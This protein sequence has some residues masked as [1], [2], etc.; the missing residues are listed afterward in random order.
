MFDVSSFLDPQTRPFFLRFIAKLKESCDKAVPSSTH[1]F[2][3]SLSDKGLLLRGYTQNIDDLES[4]VGLTVLSQA[5]PGCTITDCVGT[6]RRESTESSSSKINIIP[7]HGTLKTVA[8]TVCRNKDDFD[9]A[10][11]AA[12]HNGHVVECKNCKQRSEDRVKQ[13][14][15][16]LQSG[17][18]RPDIVL[19]NEHHHLGD[20]ISEYV[21]LDIDS[22]PTTVIVMGTSLR[23]TG[24]KKLVKDMAKAVQR[25]R[26]IAPDRTGPVIYVNKTSASKS[27]WRNVFDAEFLGTCDEWVEM[28]T[29]E[30]VRLE[31][32]KPKFSITTPS[33]SQTKITNFFK[34]RPKNITGGS[35]KPQGTTNDCSNLENVEHDHVFDTALTRQS[36]IAV[37]KSKT[38]C[39]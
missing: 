37:G 33:P 18:Y 25:K 31:I 6:K 26:D 24:L 20:L 27:E 15:R 5:A 14:R 32:S 17:I 30:L 13:G 35:N 22:M 8:C 9:Q 23:V 28:V 38:K 3:K 1:K 36:K 7:L 21:S 29:A 19:Y 11:L 16:R 39:C 34:T 10:M 12:F 2:F 4:K